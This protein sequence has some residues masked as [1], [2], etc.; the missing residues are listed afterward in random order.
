MHIGKLKPHMASLPQPPAPHASHDSS[1]STPSSS[2]SG[3]EDM[4]AGTYLPR[5]SQTSKIGSRKYHLSTRDCPL[6]QHYTSWSLRGAR[7]PAVTLI[8]ILFPCQRLGIL[9]WGIIWDILAIKADER[10]I[11]KIWNEERRLLSSYSVSWL[12][13]CLRQV[14]YAW[15][16]E[17]PDSVNDGDIGGVSA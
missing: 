3:T 9:T 7:M 12:V 10:R 6:H 8:P 5:R 17:W 2:P 1:K 15:L 13:I 16:S 4:P 11:Y 14:F